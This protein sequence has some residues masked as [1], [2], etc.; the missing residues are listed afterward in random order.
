MPGLAVKDGYTSLQKK[1]GSARTSKKSRKRNNI[2]YVDWSAEQ[3]SVASSSTVQQQAQHVEHDN[4]PSPE[5]PAEAMNSTASDTAP[6]S[7][8]ILDPQISDSSLE[9]YE[10][11]VANL[12]LQ[13][14]DSSLKSYE[15]AA[16]E[17][18]SPD[19]RK[20]A[21]L[22][23]SPLPV[24]SEQPEQHHDFHQGQEEEKADDWPSENTR[25][26]TQN[27]RYGGYPA[28][29][30][31]QHR[32]TPLGSGRLQNASKIGTFYPLKSPIL[33]WKAD[34]FELVR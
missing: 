33:Q 1:T 10:T 6:G 12:D 14:S 16:R 17:I 27:L 22:P 31:P 26:N 15:T 34:A 8:P 5:V 23:D 2:R 32:N 25:P 19:S 7:P 3:E 29:P 13:T 4:G 9:S 24:T 18:S 20:D 21:P 11:A 30:A 28:Q